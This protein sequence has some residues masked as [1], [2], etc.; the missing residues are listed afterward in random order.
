MIVFNIIKERRIINDNRK[1]VKLLLKLWQNYTISVFNVIK[2]IQES[3]PL[4]SVNQF[5]IYFSYTISL[6]HG[7]F[8]WRIKKRYKEFQ[9]LHQQLVLFKTGLNIPFPSKTHSN[10]RKSFK[11][12]APVTSKGKRKGQLPR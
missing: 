12:N 9:S 2:Y 10:K 5:S 3:N 11:N 6:I 4:S 1:I 8:T 7:N